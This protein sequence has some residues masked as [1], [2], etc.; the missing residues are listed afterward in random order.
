M[1]TGKHCLFIENTDFDIASGVRFP[2]PTEAEINGFVISHATSGEY[3][4]H[5]INTGMLWRADPIIK[6]NVSNIIASLTMG[7]IKKH[8]KKK[9]PSILLAGLGNPHVSADAL[10][11]FVQKNIV[12]TAGISGVIP[13]IYSVSP[14]VESQ[15]GFNT[16]SV[17]HSL[18]LLANADLVVCV[19]S[20]T[21]RSKE[22]LQTV[23]QITDAGISPGSGVFKESASLNDQTLPCPVISIGV[24][25]AIS[26]EA[27][28]DD[29][30]DPFLFTRTESAIVCEC[31]ASVIS[32]GLNK[33]F[34]GNIAE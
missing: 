17:I 6:R 12:P 2:S 26:M 29:S 31:Y 24:P 27:L 10:G 5:T 18:S 9:S 4:Y 23:L 14:G 34:L 22:R 8:C 28:S 15:T 13:S 16:V 19:D 32:S 20:L 7:Y 25:M 21:A 33:A 3:E 11:S 1:N 30:S